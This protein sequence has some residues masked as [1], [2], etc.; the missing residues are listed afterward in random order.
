M[1][2][3]MST[4]I[5]TVHEMFKRRHIRVCGEVFDSSKF[6]ILSFCRKC[7]KKIPEKPIIAVTECFN[8]MVQLSQVR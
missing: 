5:I 1:L 4:V 7:S 8:C 6:F 3:D 2:P